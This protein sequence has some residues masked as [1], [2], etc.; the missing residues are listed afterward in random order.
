MIS[1]FDDPVI[2]DEV[3]DFSGRVAMVTG[4]GRGV[5]A[6]IARTLAEHGAAVAVNDVSLERAEESV[7]EITKCGGSAMAVAAD[8]TDRAAVDR[9]VAMVAGK[10]G[11]VD[12]L[13]NNAGVPADGLPVGRFTE[14][15][16]A[17][18]KPLIDL[19]L[20][21]VLH[22]TQ[23]VLPGMIASGSGRLVHIV[24]DSGRV[25]EAGIAVY[26]AAKAATIGFS[27]SLAKEVGRFGVTSNSVSLGA[28][29]TGATGEEELARRIRRYPIGR[30]GAPAD[31]APA[32]VW[33][34]STEAGWV[35]GQT[36]SV[37]GGY[38]TS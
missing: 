15:T 24:S 14:S 13:V 7:A 17:Q 27:R 21:A 11:P 37:S 1:P 33:L 26:S 30:V 3:F 35:T 18:W 10:F 6:V 36:V 38:T 2:G 4:A 34:A 32:V 5:G 12:V 25:G 19:N 16:A 8:V 22:C 9:M 31:V 28:I 20:Y 29:E 23:A